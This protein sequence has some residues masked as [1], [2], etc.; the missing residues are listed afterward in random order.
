MDELNTI[1]AIVA[2]GCT[3]VTTVVTA[4]YF[5]LR[6]A[7]YDGA[8]KQRIDDLGK[9]LQELPCADHESR[10]TK[11]QAASNELKDRTDRLP[12][13]EY[14]ERIARIE[15]SISMPKP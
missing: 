9:R 2:S 13:K 12:C 15:G 4:I 6:W 8:R 11:M 14:G 5:A 3:V 1:L 7:G 10:L